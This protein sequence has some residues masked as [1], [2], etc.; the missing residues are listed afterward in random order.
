MLHTVS[1]P[2]GEAASSPHP[3]RTKLKKSSYIRYLAVTI[4]I[5]QLHG[6]PGRDDRSP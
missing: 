1:P 4:Q 6:E 5:L 3:R 2:R